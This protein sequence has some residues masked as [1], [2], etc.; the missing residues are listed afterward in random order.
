MCILMNSILQGLQN[1]SFTVC[2]IVGFSEGFSKKHSLGLFFL[3][4]KM[5]A[6]GDLFF[7]FVR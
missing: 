4:K 3:E 5:V 6:Q 7:L 2:R 1:M